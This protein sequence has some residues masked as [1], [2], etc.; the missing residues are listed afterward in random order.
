MMPK[1]AEADSLLSCAG[2]HC[3]TAL[4]APET[5]FLTNVNDSNVLVPVD[6]TVSFKC[7]DGKRGRDD[8]NFTTIEK[9]CIAGDTYENAGTD[10]AL[11]VQCTD[12]ESLVGA[13][14]SIF[15]D[16]VSFRQGM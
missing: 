1:R 16:W 8:F 5:L 14:P 7:R 12:R 4:Q 3:I 11:W 13:I 6:S 10:P 2:S 15:V 9:K